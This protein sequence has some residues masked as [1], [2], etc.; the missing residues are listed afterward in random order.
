MPTEIDYSRLGD[1]SEILLR[2]ALR[3]GWSARNTVGGSVTISAPPPNERVTV[4]LAA[5]MN[6]KKGRTIFNKIMRFGDQVQVVIVRTHADL[7]TDPGKR[8]KRLQDILATDAEDPVLASTLMSVYPKY[9]TEVIDVEPVPPGEFLPI[10]KAIENAKAVAESQKAIATHVVEPVVIGEK[11]WMA[12]KGLDGAENGRYYPSKT[13][14]ER[15]WSDGSTDYRCAK[16]GCDYSAPAPGSVA[17]HHGNSKDHPPIGDD[18]QRDV[19]RG[20]AYEPGTKG[21][22]T[23]ASKLAREIEAALLGMS[24]DC[25]ELEPADL[26]AALARAIADMRAEERGESAPSVPL[27][28]EQKLERIRNIVDDGSM[29]S[30]LEREQSLKEQVAEL[31]LFRVEATQSMEAATFALASLMEQYDNQKE[32][33]DRGTS[34]M[35]VARTQMEDLRIENRRLKGDWLA[36]KDLLAKVQVG[37]E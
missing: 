21:P 9:R 1:H 31:E 20:P 23:G 35:E 19:I 8:D 16:E 10:P 17:R 11:P 36:L 32:A 33:L 13:T 34:L 2:I 5:Q 25:S 18:Y 28:A 27:T 24:E 37:G 26:A 22:R 3:T 4:T 12:R 15:K 7:F 6:A 14:I 30:M 29:F